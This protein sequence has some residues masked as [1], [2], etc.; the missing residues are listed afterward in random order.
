MRPK[1]W[2]W[3]LNQGYSNG[4]TGCVVIAE[5]VMQNIEEIVMSKLGNSF[6]FRSRYGD[7]NY[8]RTNN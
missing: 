7:D 8:V 6:K 1:S 4:F 3:Y 5:I 2:T